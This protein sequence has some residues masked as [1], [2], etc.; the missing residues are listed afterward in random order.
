MEIDKIWSR[1]DKKELENE[2]KINA[3]YDAKQSELKVKIKELEDEKTKILE[4]EKE[5]KAKIKNAAN[6]YI[7]TLKADKEEAILIRKI[8]MNKLKDISTNTT[9]KKVEINNS[10]KDYTEQLFQKATEREE[11]IQLEKQIAQQDK[12]DLKEAYSVQETADKEKQEAE[13]ATKKLEKEKE[14]L[15]KIKLQYEEELKKMEGRYVVREDGKHTKT[16]EQLECENDL[17]KIKSELAGKESDLLKLQE[18][19]KESEL[20]RKTAQ[21][22]INHLLEKYPEPKQDKTQQQVSNPQTNNQQQN[23]LQPNNSQ[24][25]QPQRGELHSI[26][27]DIS[28]KGSKISIERKKDDNT[29][30]NSKLDNITLTDES[31]IK[32]LK[33]KTEVGDIYVEKALVIALEEREITYEEASEQKNTYQQILKAETEEEANKLKEEMKLNLS[34]NLRGIRRAGISKE[35]RETLEKNAKQARDLG[36]AKVDRFTEVKW[37]LQ[38]WG[39]KAK[40]AIQGLSKNIVNKL[41]GLR[42]SA[43][44]AEALP[45]GKEAEQEANQVVDVTAQEP[46][47]DKFGNRIQKTDA[48]KAMDAQNAVNNAQINE[49]EKDEDKLQ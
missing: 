8:A 2:E 33:Q 29:I 10:I 42:L 46:K 16:N 32:L 6:T 43:N 5:E 7:G 22:K 37:T 40:T 14:S 30:E 36:I 17:E 19:I 49:P 3:L 41:K 4:V 23:N 31:Y 38:E 21:E 28:S 45:E 15:E 25:V 39:Q 44:E 34:Y 48:E 18:T 11:K 12:N 20:K 26:N 27:L 47:T 24:Q 35:D 13:E 9:S 1:I